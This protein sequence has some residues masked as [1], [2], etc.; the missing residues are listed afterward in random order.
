M[1]FI[2]RACVQFAD[3]NLTSH[4]SFTNI[5]RTHLLIPVE[6]IYYVTLTARFCLRSWF[7]CTA[8]LYANNKMLLKTNPAK[9]ASKE[10]FLHNRAVLLTLRQNDTLSVRLLEVEA[11]TEVEIGLYNWIK[12]SG[13]L[14]HANETVNKTTLL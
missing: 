10:C 9:P 2:D 7:C 11:K 12:L 5:N 14:V 1:M 13:F 4:V 8:G 6:G 3:N